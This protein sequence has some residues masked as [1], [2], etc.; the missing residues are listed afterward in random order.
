[1][2][3]NNQQKERLGTK[4]SRFHDKY[5]KLLLIIPAVILLFSLVYCVILMCIDFYGYFMRISFLSAA[6]FITLLFLVVYIHDSA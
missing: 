6:M 2:E 3:E 4:I 5:Y 1:M